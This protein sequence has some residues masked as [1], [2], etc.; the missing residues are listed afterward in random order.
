MKMCPK[1]FKLNLI[2]DVTY[3]DFGISKKAISYS[4]NKTKVMKSI[5]QIYQI[6]YPTRA[7]ITRG[8]YIFYPIFEDN[9]FVFKEVFSENYGLIYG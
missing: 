6:I 4:L 5:N 1:V 7:I 8:L 9:F 3:F 2:K